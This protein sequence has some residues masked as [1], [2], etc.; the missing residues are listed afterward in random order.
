M[1][2]G[3]LMANTPSDNQFLRFGIFELEI[4]T[5]ELRKS[6][7]LVRLRPQAVK[8]LAMLASLPGQLVTR[9]QLRAEIW[10]N[11]TFVD[12][13]HGLNLCVGEIRAAL[14]DAA[15][16]PRYIET[17][18]KHGYR[19]IASVTAGVP[20]RTVSG[21]A[22]AAEPESAGALESR[23]R[24]VTLRA[25]VLVVFILGLITLVAFTDPA[26][27]QER[28][29][30][31]FSPPIRSMAVLP[32][33]NLSGDATQEYF[34]DG[35]TDALIASLA[36]I[37]ALRVISRTS[38]MSYKGTRKSLPEIARELNVDAV[39]E[40]SVVTSGDQVRITAQLIRARND[41]HLWAESYQRSLRDILALQD[42]VARTIAREIQISLTPQE[43][44][45]LS[46]ARAINPQAHQAYLQGLY[47][48]GKAGERAKSVEYFQQAIQLDSDYAPP[49]AALAGS[50]FIPAFFETISPKEAYQA[51]REAAS[52]ALERDD[53]LPEAHSYLA[54][55]KL[56]ADW[57]WPGAEREFKRAIELNPSNADVRHTYAHFL[58]AMGRGEEALAE[59]ERALEL[60]PVGDRLAT[61][62]GWHYVWA[63]EYDRAIQQSLGVLRTNQNS[64]FAKI[65]LGWA[66]EQKS[67][68]EES[69]AQLQ[70]S[71]SN[72]QSR[73]LAMATLGYTYAV[74][75]KRRQAHEVLAKLRET[76]AQSY[77]SPYQV[78]AI[79]AGL[80][81]KDQ[82]FA[83]L[84][85]AYAERSSWLVHIK[86]DPRL[87]NL[88]LDPRFQD[89][90]RRIGLPL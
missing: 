31:S 42:E 66:Y 49:Y 46:S 4:H 67:M 8:V 38:V 51:M 32:L 22:A 88:R 35:M 3:Y 89:L 73:T 1:R 25:V 27:W 44:T 2:L 64:S 47:Y 30:A 72:P 85:K 33:E 39:V 57:D 81:D 20:D 70:A 54:L 45:R 53:T 13:E 40:G 23:S 48:S 77:V 69:I 80:G 55:T 78:A 90:V 21:D 83:W 56:H 34:A 84:E 19:F 29:F 86:W 71:L 7:R 9:E 11:Q 75:G 5:G 63:R 6:G 87:T 65:N 43:Q 79:Y 61:C 10:G 59:S 12:F 26:Q 60:D 18:P 36:K 68:F 82:A 58:M 74:S 24:A 17:L 41:R 62:L 15:G 28:L 37:S 76:A 14:S 50:Y 16:S 52:K